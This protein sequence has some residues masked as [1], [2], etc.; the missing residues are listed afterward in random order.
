MAHQG[1]L[2]SDWL[3]HILCRYFLLPHFSPFTFPS[4]LIENL[5]F[6]VV[7]FVQGN[8]KAMKRLILIFQRCHFV[9]PEMYNV[10]CGV[11][12]EKI[13]ISYLCIHSFNHVFHCRTSA[14]LDVGNTPGNTVLRI[15]RRTY[16]TVRGWYL[17]QRKHSRFGD[18]KW[19]RVRGLLFQAK[20]TEIT[21]VQSSEGGAAVH[22]LKEEQA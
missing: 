9:G 8:C 17:V 13:M 16:I 4:G 12:V 15:N 21:V 3:L 7:W 22:Y 18:G 1:L 2:L 20:W 5:G 11:S 14:V 6:P 10:E 19:K